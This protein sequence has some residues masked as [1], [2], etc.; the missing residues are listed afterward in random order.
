MSAA[1]GLAD[2][3]IKNSL[4]KRARSIKDRRV[5]KIA[6]TP[7]G[8]RVAKSVMQ[9]RYKMIKRMFEKI[10]PS[11]REKYLQILENVRKGLITWLGYKN[12]NKISQNNK[13]IH[14]MYILDFDY[15]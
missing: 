6:I 3:M 5:V 7:K 13:Y 14:I 1:T 15:Y 4:L 2:R 9:Q 8:R 12:E 11:D 10:T